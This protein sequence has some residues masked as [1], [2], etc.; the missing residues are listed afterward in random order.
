MA[1]SSARLFVAL[2]LPAEVLAAL[3]DWRAPLLTASDGALRPVPP[4]SLHVTLC[5][6]GA[7]PVDAVGPLS[8]AVAAVVSTATAGGEVTAG[9]LAVAGALWLP[10]RR[11]RV[12]TVE[13]TDG[14]GSL[15]SLQA[16]MA[17][18]LEAGGWFTR[19]ERPFLPH[20][21]VARARGSGASST[22]DPLPPPPALTFAGTAV[23]LYRSH[24]G[25][26]PARYEP[27]LRVPLR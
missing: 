10:R 5:F 24:V 13:L 9:G 23:A 14:D 18:G 8:D 27:V 1:G 15:A 4:A 2:D 7:L 25:R 11:P 26:G 17:D 12:L 20:V 21:T 6:L 16:A 3:I 22:G 19:E